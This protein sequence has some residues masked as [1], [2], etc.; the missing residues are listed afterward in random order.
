[1]V[2]VRR[3]S[4]M[5]RGGM[6]Q[7]PEM[8]PSGGYLARVVSEGNVPML[9]GADT[10]GVVRASAGSTSPDTSS[11]PAGAGGRGRPTR[12]AHRGWAGRPGAVATAGR[13]RGRRP[14]GDSAGQVVIGSTEA[15]LIVTEGESRTSPTAPR[16]RRTLRGSPTRR[17][18]P[19]GR[20][21]DPRRARGQQ[22]WLAYVPPGTVGG[23]ASGT[24]ELRV[25]RLDGS[26]PGC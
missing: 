13:P 17:P 8:S 7:P 2:G 11:D 15:G 6:E 26:A 25:Q 19:D 5:A 3:D 24:A 12:A 4:A 23:E 20:R 14:R 10:E 21:A 9:A 18:R 16:A 1:M 22:E